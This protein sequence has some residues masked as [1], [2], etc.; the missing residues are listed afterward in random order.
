MGKAVNLYKYADADQYTYFTRLK[1]K[2]TKKDSSCHFHSPPFL[3]Y[4]CIYMPTVIWSL[5][6]SVYHIHGWCL[7]NSEEGVR[8][9]CDWSYT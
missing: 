1:S 2:H 9:H 4:L 5:Y 6:M 3:S 8:S 7:Q